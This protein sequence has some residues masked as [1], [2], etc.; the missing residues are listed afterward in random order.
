M[1]NF[2][3]FGNHLIILKYQ[4]QLQN[5]NGAKM[6]VVRFIVWRTSKK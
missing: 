6:F 2:V 3:D 5:F 4:M 1:V